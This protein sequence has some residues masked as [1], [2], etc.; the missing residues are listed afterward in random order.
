[1]H[2]NTTHFEAVARVLVPEEEFSV[3]TGRSE[4]A[5]LE[6]YKKTINKGSKNVRMASLVSRSTKIECAGG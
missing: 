5:V 4:C 1:M 2:H 3:R 6:K